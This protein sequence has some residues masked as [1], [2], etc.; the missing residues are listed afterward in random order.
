MERK[1]IYTLLLVG[2]NGRPWKVCIPV[3]AV[4][5]LVV[6]IILGAVGL[7]VLAKSYGRMLLKVSNYNSLRSDRE[8]LKTSYQSLQN[9]VR[10]TDK[11]LNSLESLA[12]E[13]AVSYGFAKTRQSPVLP[14]A[15]A[16][17]TSDETGSDERYAASLYAFNRVEQGLSGSTIDRLQ[18]GFLSSPDIPSIWPVEG[19]VTDWFGERVDPFSGM[20]SFHPGVDIAAPSGTPVRATADGI[21][22]EAGREEA[23]YGNEVLIDHGFGISTRY[24]HLRRIYVVDGQEVKKGQIIGAVGMT[25]RA[26]GPHLHYEVLVHQTPVNPSK[27]LRG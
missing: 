20:E 16:M 12:S 24:G 6:L 14:V 26:T 18:G 13:V 5:G 2:P 4:Y 22:V 23:G 21:V 9:T 3:I 15:A 25:G 27:F 11:Q 17:I 7:T 8:S 19:E 1:R 10:H